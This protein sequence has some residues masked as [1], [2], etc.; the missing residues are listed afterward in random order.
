M[1]TAT[2]G[3]QIWQARTMTNPAVPRIER[4]NK[5]I[6]AICNGDTVIDTTNALYVWEHM[7]YP[8]FY[9]PID[10]LATP[11]HNTSGTSDIKGYVALDWDAMDAWYEEDEQIYVHARSP[12]TRIDALRSSR[13]VQV[14]ID[15]Q[16]VADSTSPVILFESGLP[17]RY[18]LPPLDVRQ[19][20]LIPSDTQTSCPYKGT[21][22]YYSIGEH[23]DIVWY[24]PIPLPESR[25]VQG[26]Y[27]FYNE[28]VDLVIDGERLARPATKFS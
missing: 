26:L 7:Y 15:G 19:E 10:D 14:E 6:R 9:F 11:C 2:E 12:Y 23:K 18:Y 1:N 13:H 20:L 25:P 17:P 21:A 27:C 3:D 5:R 4:C 24:Y 22:S 8:R 16:I 28:K